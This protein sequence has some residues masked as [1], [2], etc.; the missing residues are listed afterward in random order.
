MSR[1]L[2]HY[3]N[4]SLKSFTCSAFPLNNQE[5]LGDVSPGVPGAQWEEERLLA[6]AGSAPS[7]GESRFA[8]RARASRLHA[9]SW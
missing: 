9:G 2:L 1:M 6:V 8:S 7:L 3:V 5:P 4:M